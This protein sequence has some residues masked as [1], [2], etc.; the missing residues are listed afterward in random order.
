M[1]GKTLNSKFQV[2]KKPQIPSPKFDLI[3]S[4]IL[5]LV[6][7]LAAM[8]LMLSDNPAQAKDSLLSDD[9]GPRARGV[10]VHDAGATEAFSPKQDRIQFMVNRAITNL[11]GKGTVR[12]AWRSLVSTQDVV[13][14]K[15]FSMPGPK[16]GTRPAVV[17]AVVQGLLDAGLAPKHILVWDK[18]V[19]DLKQA[20]FFDLAKR[21]GIRVAGSAQA[22][23]DEKAFYDAALLGN[24]VWG[25]HEFGKEGPGVGRKSFVS[26][27][28]TRE[29]TKIINI[30]PL[31]NH[32]V[33]GVSG[34]LYSLATGS[35][36]NIVRFEFEPERLATAV[37]DIYNL[38]ALGDR[39]VLNITDALISQYEGGERGLLHYSATLNELRF[40]KDPVALD[41]L[42]LQEL[43]R[44]RKTTEAPREKANRELY[45]NASLIRLGV[46]D[47]K[48]IQIERF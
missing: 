46:S 7:C 27:L 48:R 31:L 32:N 6:S 15:V 5:K 9:A 34:N 39:V 45:E 17:A 16:S 29:M 25:D 38:P 13:G 3:G 11:A 37:P 35:V 4:S 33:A 18:Q 40:S 30:N 41:V 26:K 44:L 28:V 10:I 24:L 19:A 8:A 47:V 14:I 36:D 12:G 2:P 1:T 42:S 21:Y 23:Y 43:D 20:G 22:G